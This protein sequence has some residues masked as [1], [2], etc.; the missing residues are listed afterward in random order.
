M[1]SLALNAWKYLSAHALELGLSG[2]RCC[3]RE[4]SAGT[5]CDHGGPLRLCWIWML[6]RCRR[7]WRMMMLELLQ[8][9][10]KPFR[11][12]FFGQRFSCSWRGRQL[13]S[14]L[15]LCCRDWRRSGCSSM[16]SRGWLCSIALFCYSWWK[17]SLAEVLARSCLWSGRT[18]ELRRLL[19]LH[20]CLCPFWRRGR[21]G[22]L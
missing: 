8:Q 6:S 16:L 2:D 9:S 7:R 1:A 17:T 21:C 3:H 19:V 15:R 10:M 20:A 22:Q 13:W 14:W 5:G 12:Y 18:S 11:N 4:R